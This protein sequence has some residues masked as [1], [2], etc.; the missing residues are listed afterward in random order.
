MKGITPVISVILLLLVTI[1]IVGF[2]TGFFQRILGAAGTSADEQL[3]ATATQLGQTIKIDIAKGGLQ[4][5][6]VAGAPLDSQIAIRSTGPKSVPLKSIAVFVANNLVTCNGW[7]SGEL[8]PGG[9]SVCTVNDNDCTGKEVK[10]SAP[11]GNAP[12]TVKC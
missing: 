1:A 4:I 9:T 12:E 8:A 3:S 11:G 5:G 10:A 7:T 6:G 2:A